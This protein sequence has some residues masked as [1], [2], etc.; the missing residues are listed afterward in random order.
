MP[1]KN[2]T[3]YN[4]LFPPS[5]FLVP[6]SNETAD[7]LAKM[8]SKNETLTENNTKHKEEKKSLKKEQ[9]KLENE[10]KKLTKQLEVI[11]GT[12]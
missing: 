12:I 4:A 7:K 9:K 11:Y 2:Q 8:Q 3:I 10:I 5:F 6:A 1:K